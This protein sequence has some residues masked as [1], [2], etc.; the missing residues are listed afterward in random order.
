M[1]FVTDSDSDDEVL[2]LR[3]ALIDIISELQHDK[4]C[5]I[6]PT[7]GAGRAYAAQS[8]NKALDAAIKIVIRQR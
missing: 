1:P 3:Q 8:L 5:W 7:A 4:D 2:E 6:F